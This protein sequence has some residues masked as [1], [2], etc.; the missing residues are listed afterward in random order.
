M[1]ITAPMPGCVIKV[2]VKEGDVVEEGKCLAIIEA[3]KMET[4]LYAAIS[5]KVKKVR[6]VKGKQVNAG[7]T[8]IELE[9]I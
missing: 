3:M 9:E 7:E 6:V 2:D 4:G 8:L 5:G 1:T